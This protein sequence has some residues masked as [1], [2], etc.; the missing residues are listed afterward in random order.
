[1]RNRLI[2]A[3][4]L[5]AFAAASVPVAAEAQTRPK[6]RVLVCDGKTVKRKSNTG[7]VVG[8]VA[9]GVLGNAV[10]SKGVKTEGTLL[11][12]GVGAVVGHEVAKKQAKKRNCRY[13]YR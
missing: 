9:G 13:V 8:A 2:A 10:A 5:A 4:T 6:Q 11:G 1:M 3:A 12:A 7:T